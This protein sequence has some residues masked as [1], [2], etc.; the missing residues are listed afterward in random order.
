MKS[1]GFRI[2][3]VSRVSGLS[4]RRFV[5]GNGNRVRILAVM[6]YGGHYVLP[7]QGMKTGLNRG[8]LGSAAG[9]WRPVTVWLVKP[10]SNVARNALGTEE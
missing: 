7:Q 8:I 10:D 4:F 9:R 3:R 5:D 6:G 2:E 1:I